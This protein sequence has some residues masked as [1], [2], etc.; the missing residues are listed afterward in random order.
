MLAL[1]ASL[2]LILNLD[3]TL[4]SEF[5]FELEVIPTTP[6]PHQSW[7]SPRSVQSL[8]EVLYTVAPRPETS[9]L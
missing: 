4:V 2:F 7:L 1:R 9:G 3:L 5:L 8:M 6:V